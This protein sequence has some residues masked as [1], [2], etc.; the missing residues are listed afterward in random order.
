[1]DRLDAMTIL[2]SAADLGS[3]SAAGRK[4]GIPL[5]S[6]SRKITDLEAHLQTQLFVRTT[7]K[8][9]LTDAGAAFVIASRR[10]LEQ[11]AEAERGA[12]GAALA[13]TGELVVTAPIVFGRLHLL[14]VVCQFLAKH[15]QIDVRLSLSDRNADLID[16]NIDVALRIGALPDSSLQVIKVGTVR[17]VVCG[18]PAYFSG[19]GSPMVPDD[20]ST[21]AVVAF[22]VPGLSNWSFSGKGARREHSVIVH[23]RLTV[24]TAEAAVDAAIAGVGLTRVLSYQA[25]DAVVRG[26]LKI[27]LQSFEPAPVPVSLVHPAQAQLPRKTR[28][29][30]DHAGDALRKRLG[31]IS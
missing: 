18:S 9:S 3:L 12:S 1:M 19:H 14:P 27:V 11:V 25:A 21:H 26:K 10:I 4:L 7:R 13:L 6:V 30:L 2:V 8:L 23:P 22:G 5:P 28:A 15:P 20:L 16:D 24:N 31:Q 29:F 17:R